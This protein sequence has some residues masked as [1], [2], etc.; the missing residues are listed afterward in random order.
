MDGDRAARLGVLAAVPAFAGCTREELARIDE[1]GTPV[2]CA[3]GVVLQRAGRGVRQV[4]VLLEGSVLEVA[5]GTT[6]AFGPSRVVG[7]EALRHPTTP[8]PSSVATATP[9]S[10]LVLGRSEVAEVAALEGVRR[11]LGGRAAVPGAA[12]DRRRPV[13]WGSPAPSFA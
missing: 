7:G 11:S 13:A 6:R 2:R 10:A 1:L 4:V 8:A 9:V 3:A 5:H 12:A